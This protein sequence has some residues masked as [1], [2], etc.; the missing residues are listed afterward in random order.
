[1]HEVHPPVAARSAIR[2]LREFRRP[3]LWLCLWMLM[4]AAVI[5]GS[6]L[7]AGDLPPAPFDGFDK[8]EHF[9]GYAVLSAYG[10]MLFARMRAQL[11]TAAGLVALGIGLEIAQALLTDSRMGDPSDAV[12][13]TL[14]ALVGVV[15]ASTPLAR[16]LQ[17]LDA[18][19]P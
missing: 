16:L 6:L 14:G 10:G 7:P 18:R 12:A 2:V 19:L 5:V 4:L 9:L 8:V 15:S 11:R 13:G 3:A 17:R 1:M